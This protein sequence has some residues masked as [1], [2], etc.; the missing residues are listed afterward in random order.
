MKNSSILTADRTTHLK[1][2]LV[3]LICATVIAGIGIASRLNDAIGT[4]AETTII[5]VGPPMTA[6]A[7]Q[8]RFVR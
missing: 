5:K 4:R 3:S 6:A 1:I 2:V 7:T 8:D